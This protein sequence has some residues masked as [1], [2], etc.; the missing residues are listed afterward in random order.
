M[1]ITME[2][3]KV[4]DKAIAVVFHL[5]S[6]DNTFVGSKVDITGDGVVVNVSLVNEAFINV[7]FNK[8]PFVTPL[9]R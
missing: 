2:N 1:R 7:A 5:S 3:K 8:V 9:K 4:T 6:V